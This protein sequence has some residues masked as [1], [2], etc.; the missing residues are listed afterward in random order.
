[1]QARW[2]LPVGIGATVV[3]QV[4]HA[5]QYMSVEQAQ[6]AA[7]ASATRFE[8]IAATIDAAALGVADSWKP[9]IWRVWNGNAT[10]GWFFEDAVIGKS[11]LI[12]Y[13]LALD[14][15]GKVTKL[16]I[17]DYRESHGGEVRLAAWRN[18]F[19]DKTSAD[20]VALDRDIRNISGATLSC[21][22]LTQGVHRLLQLYSH[23]LAAKP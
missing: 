2:L 7:F 5:A 22:H 9:L 3:V 12:T 10:A 15:S 13:S 16:E 18:Q 14:A 6:R 19:R 21:R 11:E 20:P 1:M 4:A 23:V 8:P 17:L